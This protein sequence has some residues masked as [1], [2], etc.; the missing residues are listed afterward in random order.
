MHKN[1]PDKKVYALVG[2]LPQ[3]YDRLS[4][5]DEVDDEVVKNSLAIMVDC[6]ETER[7][8]DQRVLL[9]KQIIKID[10]HI[11]GKP[12]F[13]I[14]WV[15]EDSIACCQMIAELAFECKFKISKLGKIMLLLKKII[16]HLIIMELKM[17]Q[18]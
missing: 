17:L 9:A 3:F 16:N 5:V 18:I 10:H 11:E 1:F 6:S 2:G 4:K 12:F 14:K 7:I 13:G 8:S 15:D